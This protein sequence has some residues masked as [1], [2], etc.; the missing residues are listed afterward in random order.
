MVTTRIRIVVFLCL[1][2][3]LLPSSPIKAASLA[4]QLSGRIVLSV[5]ENVNAI[6]S[7]GNLYPNP[8]SNIAGFSLTLTHESTVKVQVYNSLGSLVYNGSEQLLNGKNKLAVDCANFN[9][10]LYFVT[11]TAGN[12]KVTK[13]LVV[14]K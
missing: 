7:V 4:S 8:S 11:V 5:E 13:R 10:G 2:F 6:E 3:L 14:N 9:N 1:V 12:S